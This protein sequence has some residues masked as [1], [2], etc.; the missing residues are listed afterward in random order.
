[1][2][3]A[4]TTTDTVH[5]GVAAAAPRWSLWLIAALLAHQLEEWFGGPGFS[6]W[7]QDTLGASI[8]PERF[9]AINI[10]GFLLLASAVV[11]AVRSASF[12]WMGAAV[13]SLLFVNG[14]LHLLL[15]AAYATY[16]PGVVTSVALYL[17]LGGI[18]LF[19]MSKTLPKPV[20]WGAFLAGVGFHALVSFT[21]LS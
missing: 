8:T 15:T 7:A 9:L 3:R 5:D 2:T 18:L 12:A 1:M 10:P 6:A 14:V 21:A 11:A 20:F 16:S 19:S 4:G 17:P 13:A